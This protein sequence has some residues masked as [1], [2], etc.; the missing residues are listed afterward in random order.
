MKYNP[1]INELYSIQLSEESKDLSELKGKLRNRSYNVVFDLHNNLRS[2]YLKR[3]INAGSICSI[4]KE[5]LK[6]VYVMGFDTEFDSNT[7][8]LLSRQYS[9]NGDNRLLVCNRGSS[10]YVDNLIRDVMDVK[11]C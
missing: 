1:H 2:N 7:G 8:E 4:Q 5:K 9:F 6:H 11:S 3:G 10:F